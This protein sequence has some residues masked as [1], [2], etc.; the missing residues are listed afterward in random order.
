MLNWFR[1]LGD[2][3]NFSSIVVFVWIVHWKGNGSGVSLKAHQLYLVVFL[4]RYL[5]LFTSFYSFYNSFMKT[6]YILAT[7]SIVIALCYVE[8]AK[9][10]YSASQDDFPHLKLLV[11]ALVLALSV[12]LLSKGVL[13]ITGDE[14]D[15]HYRLWSLL[16]F[17]W[18]LS[19]C[20]EP[21]ANV[22]QLTLFRKN[23]ALNADV[24]LAIGLRGVYRLL[25]ILNY[26][27]RSWT[28]SGYRHHFLVYAAA[29]V[30]VLLYGD[31]FV[32]HAK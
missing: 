20:L 16:E 8:P 1:L 2:F 15:V 12:Y 25:Y 14:F 21:L 22:P 7:A 17:F 32:Y 18:T 3:C 11:F 6:Y 13:D 19:I 4:T 10:T 23:R 24:R 31:F 28:E 29:M 5:D 9:S 26:I 27:Y 30:Q